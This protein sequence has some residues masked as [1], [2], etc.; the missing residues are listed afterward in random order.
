MSH[1]DEFLTDLETEYPKHNSSNYISNNCG[2]PMRIKM[3]SGT[4]FGVVW[5][6]WEH[7]NTE[8]MQNQIL[9]FNSGNREID[10]FNL[11]F[12]DIKDV[13]W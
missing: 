7:Q 6:R 11:K 2:R 12:E 3:K 9:W 5:F 4:V 8:D 13:S 1:F 10:K